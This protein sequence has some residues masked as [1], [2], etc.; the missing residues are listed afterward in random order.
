MVDKKMEGGQTNKLKFNV[1]G[2]DMKKQKSYGAPSSPNK[3]FKKETGDKKMKGNDKENK[4]EK[5]DKKVKKKVY[6][7]EEK[8]A[9]IEK[10]KKYK[11][12]KNKMGGDNKKFNKVNNPMEDKKQKFDKTKKLLNK[13]ETRE[14][15]KEMK[16]GRRKFKLN[17]VYDIGVQAKKVWEEVRRED[18]PEEK[19]NKL[20]RELHALVKG[21]IKKMIYAHDTVRV[22]ECL[23]ALGDESIRNS[24]FE[25]MK[26]DVIEMCKSKYAHFFVM[27]ML[28]YGKKEQKLII[29]KEM[30]GKIAKLMKNKIAATV[31]ETI[32]TDIANGPQRVCLLQEFL[33]NQFRI[34]KEPE[35]RTVKEIIA[36]Y[37]DR[38][39]DCLRYLHDNVEVLIRKGCYNHSLVHNVLYNYF[40]TC[41]DPKQRAEI[42]E[43]LKDSLIHMVHTREGAYTALHCLW[44]SNPKERKTT[45]KTFK[46][47]MVK[48]AKEEY[49][50]MVLLGMFDCVDD[51]KFVGQTVISELVKD[52]DSLFSDKYGVR[53][54]K[55]LFGRR[56]TTYFN[57]QF[58]E[59]LEKGDGNEHSKKDTDIRHK[60][61]VAIAAPHV[62]KNIMEK[63]PDNLMLPST[64][65]LLQCIFKYSPDSPELQECFTKMAKL[66]SRPF[67]KG[68]EAPNMVENQASSMLFKKLIM[69]DRDRLA[70]GQPTF[71]SF[72]MP[73]L[74]ENNIDCWLNCNKGCVLFINILE[75]SVP[76][77]TA[78]LKKKMKDFKTLLSKLKHPT[79]LKLKEKFAA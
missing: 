67:S 34:Y 73:L 13:Q 9:F 1:S 15:Q 25:E 21:N 39:K 19:K 59:I 10:T 54:L 63:F 72:L 22:V 64:S 45:I 51:T 49:G 24:L 57:K 12:D 30:E 32:Y 5:R 6:T 14:K 56:D 50:H 38:K 27:K 20:T 40:Q 18:C 62:I 77:Y 65:I 16:L 48:T 47:F 41:E 37:P 76:E 17:E 71:T 36:K 58:T 43:Q 53:V 79:A 29:V 7:D 35:L 3:K 74:D 70:A 68:D 69:Q 23:V 52:L 42:I 46:T 4:A 31:V 2:M 61:L 11:G 28:K 78:Q 33:D 75:L 8:K 55:Y 60:E 26:E 44:N 66:L